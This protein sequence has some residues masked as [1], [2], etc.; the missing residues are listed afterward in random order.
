MTCADR[1][2]RSEGDGGKGGCQ[3]RG[4]EG[5]GGGCDLEAGEWLHKVLGL[6][7]VLG[8]EADGGA[9]VDVGDVDLEDG[10]A[11]GL[12]PAVRQGRQWFD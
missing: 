2:E 10:A 6:C 8:E 3:G 12:D 1:N 5:L 4:G 9:D 11:L 7:G